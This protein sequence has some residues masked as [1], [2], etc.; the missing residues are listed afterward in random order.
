MVA[1][2]VYPA[3]V[4]PFDSK[5]RIDLE[6]LAKL[7]AFFEASGCQ[8]VVLAGTNGEGPSLSAVEKRDLI[9]DA[10]PMKGRLDLILGIATPSLDE[11]IWLAKRADEFGAAAVLAMP[12]YYFK[13]VSEASVTNWFHALMDRSPSPVIAYN[14][15]KYT[16]IEITGPMMQAIAAHENCAGC[17]DSSGHEP[18]LRAY[19]EA[20][21]REDQVLMVGDETMLVKALESGWSGTISGAS[22]VCGRWIAAI[23]HDWHSGRQD[24]AREKFQLAEDVLASIRKGPQPALNKA[25]LAHLKILARSDVRLPLESVAPAEAERLLELVESRIGSVL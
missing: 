17:K 9:R 24:S 4:T 18:N 5:G 12:P 15:P 22:N 13:N 20:V 16:G 8:G 21:R 11:A 19:R 14:F 6:S 7:L 3:A 10:A 2:G 23:V 25:C 1:P